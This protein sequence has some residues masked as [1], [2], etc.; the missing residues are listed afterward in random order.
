MTFL[1][2]DSY[3]IKNIKI[4]YNYDRNFHHVIKPCLLTLVLKLRD[5]L[6]LRFKKEPSTRM[7][8]Q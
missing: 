6:R 5:L 8:E 1:N 7:L 3:M 4:S 2:K